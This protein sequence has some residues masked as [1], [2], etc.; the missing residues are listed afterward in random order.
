MVSCQAVLGLEQAAELFD[1][2][3][4][5][6]RGTPLAAVGRR[7]LAGAARLRGNLL[8]HALNRLGYFNGV[9]N[10]A[11]KW[12]F[13]PRD[14]DGRKRVNGPVNSFAVI[15]GVA[16]GKLR[17]KAFDALNQLKGPNGWR[18]FYPG[19][20]D[21][22]ISNLGRIGSGDKSPG[23]SENGTPYNH[24]SHGFLGRAAWS[25]GRGTMLHKILRYTFS[26]DQQA[27]PVEVSKTAPY[28]VVNHWK[29][30]VGLEGVG[31]DTFLSG[32]ISTA[33]RNCYQGM[34]GFRPGL[35]EL[36]IDPVIPAGWDGLGAEVQFLGGRWT[37]KVRNPRHA[38]CGVK[39]LRLDGKR[40]EIFRKD[41]RL[42]R[43]VAV[44]P[45]S[46]LKPGAQHVVEAMLG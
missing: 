44:I 18:L 21:P 14:P 7:F 24:G 3:S 13:S 29:E 25:G 22:P 26:Y 46:E 38:E 32:T 11:G 19:I 23:L 41:A 40:H 33:L 34:V 45:I 30:A 39:E 20:G 16:S 42:E 4:E 35:R 31:G 15:S 28:A 6:G 36:V 17:D 37:I 8:K 9:F 2:V 5:E 43:R 1:Y 27:H 12:V 10:D